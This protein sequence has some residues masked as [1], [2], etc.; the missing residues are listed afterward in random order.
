[1][2]WTSL[3]GPLLLAAAL[4]FLP[5][6]VVALAAGRRGFAAVALAPALSVTAMSTGA[7]VADWVG[8]P[9]GWWV[10]VIAGVL[11]TAVAWLGRRLL[12]RWS[13]DQ[14]AG[15]SWRAEWPLWAGAVVAAVLWVV[16][17]KRV[18]ASP[19]T[20][21]QLFDNIFHLSLVRLFAETGTGSSM[22]N[23]GLTPG[24]GPWFYPAAFHDIASLLFMAFPD[25]ITVALTATVWVIVPLV[26]P[27]S[28]L[29]L[30]SRLFRPSAL[31]VGVGILAA[32]FTGFPFLLLQWGVLYPN[33]LGLA[34]LPLA[35]GLT[36]EALGLGPAREFD[37]RALLIGAL[38]LPGLVL[39]HPT[40]LIS[41]VVIV[42]LPLVA[43][44]YRE[45]RAMRAGEVAPLT[46]RIR[47]GLMLACLPV[48]AAGWWFVRPWD[49]PW[50]PELTRFEA[51]GQA[52]LNAPFGSGP[53]WVVSFLVIAG[54]AA[55][56]R[57]GQWWLA[58]TWAAAVVLWLVAS[59]GPTGT[60]RNILTG[61]YYN[62]PYRVG[63]LLAVVSLPAAAVGL[64]ALGTWFADR[65]A[66]AAP[67][68]RAPLVRGTAVGLVVAVLALST[69]PARYLD[70]MVERMRI[71]HTLGDGAWMLTTDELT[72]IERI[73]E[74]VPAD[75]VIATNPWNGSSLVYAFTGRPTTTK[76]VF[77][78]STPELTIL[79]DHLDE[80]A[81]APEVCRVVRELGVQYVLDFGTSEINPAVHHP[82]AGFDSLGSAPGFELVDREGDVALYRVVACR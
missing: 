20:F 50:E 7:V 27:L 17:L 30:V 77:Y 51:V 55:A 24:S 58:G 71:T 4:V 21:S 42:T 34:L 5:G 54:L 3:I 81:T 26:W 8:I 49:T 37:A 64:D 74:N 10:P 47:V 13:P 73:P 61:V 48:F 59:S 35:V 69:Q 9:W 44:A 57:R 1:M 52:V 78:D 66:G 82:F 6:L 18:Y 28:C 29:Y 53:A 11:L 16:H 62:D 12:I 63:A 80:A 45:W 2:P 38:V 23:G 43:G 22:A 41:L 75:A 31:T 56:W 68:R 19:A 14:D 70:Q 40:T 79:Q 76:H 65:A 25:H 60:M 39:A 36:L 33:V 15:G 46:G 72:L 32:S 67:P